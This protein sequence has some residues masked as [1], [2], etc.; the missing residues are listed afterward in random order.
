MKKFLS[1]AMAILMVVSMMPKNIVFAEDLSEEIKPDHACDFAAVLGTVEP[2]CTEDGVK[3]LSCECGETKTEVIP[4]SGHTYVEGKCECGEA[5]PNYVAPH[6]H[7][8]VDGKCEC[9]EADP[10]YQPPHEHTFVDGKC[11]CGEV[12]GH[13]WDAEARNGL[14]LTCGAICE[15][16]GETHVETIPATCK[17][18]GYELVV[19]DICTASIAGEELPM[20]DH[21]Y[22]DGVCECGAEIAVMKDSAPAVAKIGETEYATLAEAVAAGG[23]I[24]LMVDITADEMITIAGKTITLDLNG[25]T[26]TADTGVSYVLWIQNSA[27][28]TIV[29]SGENGGIVNNNA[30]GYAILNQG[31]LT[32][33]GGT[34]VGDTALWNGYDTINS[35][36]T[37]NGGVFE[38]NGNPGE[39]FS[40]GNSGTLNVKGGQIKDWVHSFGTLT[41]N[42]GNIEYIYVSPSSNSMLSVAEAKTTIT[43]GSIHSLEVDSG[44]VTTIKGGSFTSE[45]SAEYVEDGATIT[46]DGK[47]MIKTESGLVEPVAK[48]G[49]T[50]YTSLAAAIEVGGTIELLKDV[51]LTEGVTVPAGKT[52]VLD[53]N[54][55]TVSYTSNATNWDALIANKGNLTIKDSG[56]NGKLVFTPTNTSTSY[57]SDTIE[58]TGTLTILGGTIENTV[59]SGAS[60]AIH[61]NSSGSNATLTV[62]DGKIIGAGTVIRQYVNSASTVNTVSISGATISG[63]FPVRVH[64]FAAGGK[65]KLEIS[66]GILTST[67]TTYNYVLDIQGYNNCSGKNTTVAIKGGTL[68]G[69]IGVNNVTEMANGVTI[70]GGTITGSWAIY[71][72]TGVGAFAVTGG[73]FKSTAF[74]YVN[75]YI[76]D[77]YEVVDNS[78]ETFTVQ[79]LP[80]VAKIGEQG[81]KSLQKAINAVQNGETITLLTDFAEAV[82][83]EQ[84]S[85]VSLTIDGNNK[86]FSGKITIKARSDVNATNTLTIQNFKF[87]KTDATDHCFIY[88]VETNH[89][90]VNVTVKNC[91]FEGSG[92]DSN[93]VAVKVK[94]PSNFVMEGC[95]ATK[96]HSLAQIDGGWNVTIKNSSVKESGRGISLGSIQKGALVDTITIEAKDTKYGIRIDGE[97]DTKAVIKDCNITAFIPVVVR[98]ASAEANNITFN[99]SNTLTQK[100][101]DGIKIAIGTSEYETNGTKPTA[102]T[103]R[104]VMTV[105][106]TVLNAALA[107]EAYKTVAYGTVQR[108][109]ENVYLTKAAEAMIGETYY[110]TLAEAA[111]AAEPGDTIVLLKDATL[112]EPLKISGITLDLNGKTIKG[113]VL[114][115]IAINGGTYYTSQNYKMMGP[116]ADYYKTTDAVLTMVD[117]NGS[118]TLHSGSMEQVPELWWT[119]DQQ[120]LTVGSNA[121]FK[122]P[123]G[124]TLNVRSAVVVEGTAVVDGT[125]NLYETT[126]TVKAPAGLN[127]VTTLDNYVV[128]YENGFYV[129]KEKTDTV[130]DMSNVADGKVEAG[131]KVYVNGTEFTVNGD[132]DIVIPKDDALAKRTAM[133]VTAYGYESGTAGEYPTAMYVWFVKGADSDGDGI[134]DAYTTERVSALDNFFKYEGTSI[135]VGTAKN[136]IRFFTSVNAANADKLMK[137]TLVTGGSLAGSKMVSA[138][139][140]FKI[141]NEARSEVYGGAAGSTFRVFQ[142]KD[143]RNW[144]T[145]VLT[146]LDTDAATI[147]AKIKSRPYAYIQVGN[148]I[149]TLYGGILE[150]SIY[151]V[152]K[153]NQDY[154]AAGS[155]HDQF[156]EGLISKVDNS[157]G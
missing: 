103:G 98:N 54:G 63:A 93:V 32:I 126:A 17:E 38:F 111:A 4:A 30:Y 94:T 75:S 95:T 106:D 20:A 28:V 71:D 74:D 146:G 86:T 73:T 15:H 65:G 80:D 23:E 132:L 58:N 91:T 69:N 36:A 118:I 120:T 12:C 26:I 31:T 141:N 18:V 102:P 152:A 115:T 101:T 90:P 25:H 105:N 34:F 125:V 11:E 55:K 50:P 16:D 35:V 40:V 29:D 110:T 53:L 112:T 128:V 138:G 39:G 70:S 57:S 79:K 41:V 21:V 143:G 140:W 117:I 8:F 147:A 145:G 83:V 51:T 139:T 37:I 134:C 43:G 130:I 99:G 137:G 92:A 85:G 56:E 52:V 153:Q 107:D 124:K 156:V 46:V 129:V 108:I 33:N 96:V 44:N 133:F 2:T 113:D 114:G 87:V 67:D 10:N 7:T 97:Y 157:N 48:I 22:V 119:L 59:G 82:T 144:F 131:G 5:D 66:G 64:V 19:C 24:I 116:D 45:P 89:Y 122:I 123:A 78:D 68:N 142:T 72:Y 109:G 76:V 127:V 60:Y 49:D 88:S 155:A 1:M 104:V 154:F 6:E 121:T 81:Y 84:K 3:T 42:G 77:G 27:T 135:R 61:N 47:E 150:R 13:D 136:G 14:C 151:E 149:I 148:Q 9:G 100:N 62:E